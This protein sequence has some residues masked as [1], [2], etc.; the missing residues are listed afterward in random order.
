MSEVHV[1]PEEAV[2]THRIL[3]ARIS[4]ASHFGTFPLADDGEDEPVEHLQKA[5]TE[6]GLTEEDFLVMG[7]GEGREFRRGQFRW[8][9]R[10]G[11]CRILTPR[12]NWVTS[13]PEPDMPPRGPAAWRNR[14]N[15][16]EARTC[17]VPYG[18][19]IS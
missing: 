10:A 2:E 8:K 13:R 4:I 5:L 3:G 6:A 16:A 19:R 12:G 11:C 14:P 15:E 9:S 7:F 1:S 18:T 17:A